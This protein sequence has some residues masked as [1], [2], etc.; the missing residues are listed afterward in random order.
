MIPNLPQA[1]PP[2]GTAGRVAIVLKG[3]PRLSETFI[4]QEILGLERA[5]LDILLFSMRRPTDRAVHPV[6]AEIRAPVRYLP[7]YLHDEPMRVLRGL[8]RAL[9]LPGFGRALRRFAADYLRDRTRHRCRRFGQALVLAAELPPDVRH[10]HAHFIH[11]P[12]SVTGYASLLTGLGWTCSAHAKDIWTSQPHDLS[13]KLAEA[14]W[15]VTCTRAGFDRLRALASDPARVHLSYHG[16]DL[17]RFAPPASAR[18]SA[19]GRSATVEFLTVCRA[20]EKKGLDVLLKALAR[21]PGD[22]DW[23][24]THIGGG[25]LLPALQEQAV[26]LGIGHRL[27][28]LGALAQDE[29][30]ARYRASDLFVLPCRIAA[31]GDRDGLPN[32]LV[33][34]QSQGLCC[35]STGVSG[36]PELIED[37]ETGLL[38]PPEDAEA[39]AR[40][41]G[42]AMTDPGMRRRLGQ[43]GERRVREQFDHRRSVSTVFR[44][45]EASLAAARRTPA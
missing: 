28:W 16:L 41:L 38:V 9:R 24:W 3:Y 10:L 2:P 20:V 45:L 1:A 21:L 34:A 18:E 8:L 33:E 43:A 11:T 6:N 12:A 35:V 29:V 17:E 31:D 32:V 30:L 26:A 27:A 37:G 42:R 36:V 23:R 44:L 7:E 15:V 13:R 39:L 40:A 22:L 14:S 4:A 19:D 25:E 5:G